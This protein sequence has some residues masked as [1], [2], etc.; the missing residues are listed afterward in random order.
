[1]LA[2]KLRNIGRMYKAYEVDGLMR[3]QSQALAEVVSPVADGALASRLDRACMAFINAQ[4]WF[5][6]FRDG[7][8]KLSHDDQFGIA[9]KIIAACVEL[10]QQL[11]AFYAEL[12]T[13]DGLSPDVAQCFD[14]TKESAMELFEE[15]ELLRWDAMEWQ[16]DADVCAGRVSGPFTS[17]DSLM[18]SLMH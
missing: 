10:Q 18:A 12:G 13:G 3:G 4:I 16:A 11:K 1:M 6:G 8:T 15:I 5:V 17:V 7:L 9:D 2:G 14:R